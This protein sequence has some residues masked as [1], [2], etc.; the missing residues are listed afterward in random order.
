MLEKI[1]ASV[2]AIEDNTA[3]AVS[4]LAT[5]LNVLEEHRVNE[6]TMVSN[7]DKSKSTCFVYLL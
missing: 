7:R 4:S 2:T 5:C 3:T 1:Q 6:Y